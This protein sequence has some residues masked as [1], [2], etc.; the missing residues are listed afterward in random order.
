MPDSIAQRYLPDAEAM[1]KDKE[2]THTGFVAQEVEATAKAIGYAFDGVNAPKN[3][4]DN[5]SIAYGQF[6]PSLVR[7]VQEQQQIIEMLQKQVEVAKAEI[8]VQIGKK[9]SIIEEQNKK[10]ELLLKEIQKIKEQLNNV[11]NKSK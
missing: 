10:I 11:T 4:T 5:Y 2:Y 1:A 3:P 7:A 6:V 9:L 8:P